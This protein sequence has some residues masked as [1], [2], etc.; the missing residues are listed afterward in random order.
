VGIFDWLKGK[1]EHQVFA[2]KMI[3]AL[4]KTGENRKIDYV[5]GTFEL[6]IGPDEGQVR[7][8][9]GNAWDEYQAAPRGMREEICLNFAHSFAEPGVPDTWE[10]AAGQVLPRVHERVYFG[11]TKLRAM[12]DGA[13]PDAFSFLEQPLASHLVRTLVYDAPR[14][15]RGL[16]E[17]QLEKWGVSLIDA[18]IQAMKNLEAIS[19]PAFERIRPGL[20]GSSH[21]DTHDA[22]RLLLEDRV[23]ACKVKG[24]H[25][26]FVPNRSG[27]LI[28]GSEDE[29]NLRE[30][31]RMLEKGMGGPRFMTAVPVKLGEDGW[32]TWEHPLVAKPAA[33]SRAREYA[34]QKQ[35]LETLNEKRGED[36]FVA[37]CALFEG[38][39]GMRSVG[40][41]TKGIVSWLPRTSHLV[42]VGGGANPKPL[43]MARFERALEVLEGKMQPVPD[44][45]PER[46]RVESFPTANELERIIEEPR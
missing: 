8:F 21:A 32:E 4:R 31:A 2:E 24:D 6:R 7:F 26:A 30:V 5:A 42:F 29:A 38:P 36:V 11:F 34:E 19:P 13:A 14:H 43:G 20:H 40:T 27:L 28:T 41:W 22:T 18:E 39:Q 45:Y 35:L 25:V 37:T 1:D 17:A 12:I 44:L 10:K 16:D 15:V 3:A 9:L 46:F 33:I 23:R